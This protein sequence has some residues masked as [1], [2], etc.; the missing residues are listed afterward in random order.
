M[1]RI[2]YF[3]FTTCCVALPCKAMIKS[4]LP[5]PQDSVVGA[6]IPAD[7][8]SSNDSTIL[9]RFVPGKSI[10]YSP[11]QDNE[12]AI[13]QAG[14]LIARHHREIVQGKAYIVVKGFCGS[15][16][17]A[18]ENLQAAKIRS[19]HVKS[20]FILHYGMKEDYY[21]TRNYTHAY[22]GI[23]DVVALMGIEYAPGYQPESVVEK[24]EPKPEPEPQPEPQPEKE[25]IP[26]PQPEPQLEK[27]PV[28]EPEPQPQP[29][30]ATKLIVK[31]YEF[32]PWTVST[33]LLYDAVLL[34]SLEV[35]YRFN[36]RWSAAVEGNMAWWHNNGKHKYYQLATI[37]PEVR[38]WF[39]SNNIR[40]G[41][42]LG[43]FGGGGWYDLEN[44]G[45]GY[46]GEGGMVGLSYGYRFPVGRYFSFEAGAG[47]GFMTTEYEEYL[48]LEGHYVYQQTSRTNYFGPLKLK[49]SWVWHIGQWMK[50]GGAL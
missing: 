34:P 14:E 41:H 28:A 50:K 19:N 8:K 42:Y 11:Y 22:K 3:L 2:L 5:L 23:N 39:R 10:F 16:P 9:F 29:E 43:L 30:P 1:K 48:P 15:Y 20:H 13:L 4:D 49:F 45:R 40:H 27:E 47:I 24:P 21:R 32:T 37:T 6:P 17:T 12:K 36:E 31:E 33:N 44:G 46:R 18:H 38:Y 25:P 26:E 7:M 35:E